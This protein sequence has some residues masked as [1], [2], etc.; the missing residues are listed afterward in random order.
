M[1]EIN[2]IKD[3]LKAT[4]KKISRRQY[5]KESLEEELED[6]TRQIYKAVDEANKKDRDELD[7]LL[8]FKNVLRTKF[9]SQWFKG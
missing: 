6:I 2:K 8:M 9:L 3:R 4:E 5:T 7:N 1:S